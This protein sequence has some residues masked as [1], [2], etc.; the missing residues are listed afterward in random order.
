MTTFTAV[1]LL[2]TGDL[3][4][5]HVMAPTAHEARRI[6][7]SWIGTQHRDAVRLVSLGALDAEPRHRADTVTATRSVLAAMIGAAL[8]LLFLI[9]TL[10][11]H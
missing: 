1:L 5:V 6:V 2:E 7:S 10:L 8:L 3:R 9:L 4:H 11:N